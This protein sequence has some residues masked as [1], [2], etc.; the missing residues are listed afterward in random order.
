M[1]VTAFFHIDD[2]RH[3]TS[4]QVL[5]LRHNKLKEVPGVIYELP[6]LQTLYL[7]YN[8]IK[9]IGP[10]VGKLKVCVCVCLKENQLLRSGV[11]GAHILLVKLKVTVVICKH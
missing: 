11:R 4:L 7:R 9:V 1:C 3:L 5:D 6:A 10:E 2:L 8:K